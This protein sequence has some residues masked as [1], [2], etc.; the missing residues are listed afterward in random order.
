MM[1][2]RRVFPMSQI[3]INNTCHCVVDNDLLTEAILAQSTTGKKSFTI[4]EDGVQPVIILN[5]RPTRVSRI[6][7]RYIWPK[8][9]KKGTVVHHCDR[10][11]L[12]NTVD[13]LKIMSLGSH[14]S[15]HRK[16]KHKTTG[17]HRFIKVSPETHL[18]LKVDA[19][20]KQRSIK[21]YI[22][23]LATGT[24]EPPQERI[25]DAAN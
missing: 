14:T 22:A 9:M 19:A 4:F 2:T 24:I 12:N 18:I 16:A 11:P 21:D 25:A 17:K 6:M 5:G 7:A 13:N 8:Q 23:G 1:H 10:D 15:L 20:K 3:E